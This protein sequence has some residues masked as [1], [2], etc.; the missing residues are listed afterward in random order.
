MDKI[1]FTPK[2]GQ[3]DFTPARYAPV[4]NCLVFY[5]GKILIVKR[6]KISEYYPNYWSGISGFLDDSKTIKEKT[7]EELFEELGIKPHQIKKIKTGPVFEYESRLYNK[8]WIAHPVLA[9][10][11]TDKLT[12]DWEADDA[13]WIAPSEVKNYKLAPGFMTV[14][15]FFFPKLKTK[16]KKK[17]QKSFFC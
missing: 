11:L 13:K 3:I 7:K 8:V 17:S 4:I 1:P 14:F 12:L 5:K 6:S 16:V 15:N 10:I 9:E 2:P